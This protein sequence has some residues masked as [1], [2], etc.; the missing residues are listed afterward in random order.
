MPSHEGAQAGRTAVVTGAALG[1]G[2]AYACRLAAD[3]VQVVLADV[4]DAT[5]TQTLITAAGGSA[6]T[7]A[8]SKLSPPT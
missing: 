6:V 7:L 5:G 4:G 3:G 8:A 1:I 2:R